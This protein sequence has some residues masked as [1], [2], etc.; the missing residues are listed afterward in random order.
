LT[1]ESRLIGTDL[2]L[3]KDLPHSAAHR[4]THTNRKEKR[5]IWPNRAVQPP[6][7]LVLLISRPSME[8]EF[9]MVTNRLSFVDTS[10]T[11]DRIAEALARCQAA[12]ERTR[13]E[14]GRS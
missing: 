4:H 11:L 12:L 3:H 10:I 6:V 1:Y 13:T 14:G 2:S 7:V 8:L 9:T 5:A